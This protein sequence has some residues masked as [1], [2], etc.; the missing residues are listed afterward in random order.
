MFFRKPLQ[1]VCVASYKN[2]IGHQPGPIRQRDPTLRTNRENGS[3][4]MLIE[5]HAPGHAIHDDA[6]SLLAHSFS[7]T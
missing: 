6:N 1:L 4:Q 7:K 2:W 5:A 3:H